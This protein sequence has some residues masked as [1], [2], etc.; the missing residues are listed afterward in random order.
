PMQVSPSHFPDQ[1]QLYINKHSIELMR[2]FLFGSMIR[3]EPGSASKEQPVLTLIARFSSVR[4][5]EAF[6]DSSSFT[7]LP[8]LQGIRS[9]HHSREVDGIHPFHARPVLQSG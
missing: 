2:S 5:P 8:K 6:F 9:V 4:Y 1:S 3:S 7:S